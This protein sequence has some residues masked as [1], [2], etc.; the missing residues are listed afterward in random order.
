[1]IDPGTALLISGGI[2]AI[3]GF[4]GGERANKAQTEITREINRDQMAFQER[5]SNSAHQRE[6]AD[7]RAA[8]L[9]PILSARLGG[10]SSP[11]GAGAVPQIRDSVGD[12]VKAGTS[13]ALAAASAAATVE[14]IE[15]S[16]A[17]TKVDT[18]KSA[19]EIKA[20][21]ASTYEST[22][23]GAE[24]FG[25]VPFAGQE[26]QARIGQIQASTALSH[27]QK[28]N[29]AVDEIIKRYGVSS[30][31]ATAA[32]AE[33]DDSYFRSQVGKALRL[34]ELAVDAV[35]PLVNSADA[36][37]RMRDRERD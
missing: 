1:M 26:V 11:A 29:A 16:T 6:V 13:S 37:S 17:K 19:A 8:G 18:L 15:A 10:A 28:V 2:N 9:N 20:V 21:E 30:A 22:Q 35:N 5:M 23:R 32:L 12:A 4:F 27:Q 3:G 34:Q 33:I 36:V 31:K 7:L 14:N 25:R 24:I